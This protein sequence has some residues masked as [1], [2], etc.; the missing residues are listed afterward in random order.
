MRPWLR[1]AA[2][3]GGIAVLAGWGLHRGARPITAWLISGWI[4]D[5]TGFGVELSDVDLEL[6]QSRVELTG[7]RFSN[8]PPFEEQEAIFIRRL[9]VV[10]DPIGIRQRQP[11]FRRIELDVD[12]VTLVRPENGL[13]NLEQLMENIDA[14][15]NKGGRGRMAATHSPMLVSA[16]APGFRNEGAASNEADPRSGEVRIDALWLRIGRVTFI[17]YRLGQNGPTVIDQDLNREA[18]YHDVRD[19]SLL[20]NEVALDLAVASLANHLGGPAPQPSADLA[21]RMNQL[22]RGFQEVPPQT[23][24]MDG[25]ADPAELFGDILGKRDE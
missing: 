25:P 20:S 3:V 24:K 7:L 18:T 12:Q 11:W 9:L 4:R 10:A 1:G 22:L 15:G 21:D 8:P 13:S 5:A 17:D 16:G 23:P 6:R 19:L 2:L 14:W